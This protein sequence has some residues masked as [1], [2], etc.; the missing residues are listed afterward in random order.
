MIHDNAQI[1]QWLTFEQERVL[2]SELNLKNRGQQYLILQN[3]NITNNEKGVVEIENQIVLA[4][5]N[6]NENENENQ[7]NSSLTLQ[8]N[9]PNLLESMSKLQREMTVRSQKLLAAEEEEEVARKVRN[10]S[11]S[12]ILMLQINNPFFHLV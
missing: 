6:E 7:H 8:N 2:T 10:D 1:S 9:P 3:K 4:N 5:K 11:M 12:T